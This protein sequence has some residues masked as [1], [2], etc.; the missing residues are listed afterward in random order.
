MITGILPVAVVF[1]TGIASA[2]PGDNAPPPAALPAPPDWLSTGQFPGQDVVATATQALADRVDEPLFDPN[3]VQNFC[4]GIPADP[5]RCS[6]TVVDAGVGA[7]IGA[8]IGA[9]V[10]APVAIAAGVVGAVAGFVVGIPFLPTGLVIGPLLGAAVGVAVIA[11]PAALLGGALG[12]S[13]GAI[14]GLTS[15]LPA[16]A[17]VDAPGEPALSP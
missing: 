11:G 9:G 6:T 4:A 14:V 17:E 5:Q 13:V 10:S 7:A 2:A 16:A 8:G 3:L 12:A 15:P 1:G